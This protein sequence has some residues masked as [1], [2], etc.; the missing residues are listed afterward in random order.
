MDIDTMITAGKHAANWSTFVGQDRA[1]QQL[2]IKARA[3]RTSGEMFGHTLIHSPEPGI[4]KTSLALLAAKELGRKVLVVN[5]K[6]TATQFQ[7]KTLDLRDGDVVVWD[8]AQQQFPKNR[9]AHWEWMLNYMQHGFVGGERGELLVPRLTLIF[10]STDKGL[11]PETILERIETTIELKPYNFAEQTRIACG[12]AGQAFAGL[13]TPDVTT[14]EAIARAGNGK[15]RIMAR[16]FKALADQARDDFITPYDNGDGSYGYDVGMV[17]DWEGVTLDG[18]SS[19]A[20]AFLLFLYEGQNE[21]QGFD[22]VVDHLR[23]DKLAVREVERLLMEKNYV[24]TTASTKAGRQLT[25]DGL[26]RARDLHDE[27]GEL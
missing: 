11:F 15:P 7:F 21:P 1:K 13:P 24:S 5:T 20:Q 16:M 23:L 2:Q 3:A 22:R 25:N 17:C 6:M 8:E 19:E 26:L 10:A 27:M 12:M 9:R 14:A 18:L 4:G